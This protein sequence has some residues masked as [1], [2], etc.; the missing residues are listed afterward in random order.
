MRVKIFV[1]LLAVLVL[2]TL[3]MVVIMGNNRGVPSGETI[4]DARAVSGFNRIEVNGVAEVTLRQG[5]RESVT[6]E[7]AAAQATSV[8]TSVHDGT[9]TITVAD[10]RRLADWL[11]WAGH[12]RTPRITVEVVKLDR[13]ESAGAVK[14]LASH[15]RAEHLRL[16]FAG[17]CTLR[18]DDLQAATLSLQ[19]SGAVKAEIAGKVDSQ[20]IDLSGAGSYQAAHL[21]SD[22]AVVQVSGAGK[23]FVNAKTFL[24]VDISGAGM[25]EYLGDP[26]V[27]QDISGIGKVVRRDASY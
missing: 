15:L 2:A 3:G 7:A 14:L 21:A 23:A 20:D 11:R 26:K 1:A 9:L 25:V 10:Q 18:I 12:S 22:R 13:I 6:V 19:G 4:R 16:D 27:E 8:E 5:A 24:K 17:A